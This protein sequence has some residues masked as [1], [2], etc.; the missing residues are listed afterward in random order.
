MSDLIFQMADKEKYN[1]ERAGQEGRRRS[2]W[3]LE[4]LVFGL[5]NFTGLEI[6]YIVLAVQYEVYHCPWQIII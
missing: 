2:P 3:E 1:C 4:T 5:P 6:E